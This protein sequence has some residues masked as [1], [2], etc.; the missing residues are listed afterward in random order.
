VTTSVRRGLPVLVLAAAG[1]VFGDIGTSPL[2]SMQMVFASHHGLVDPTRTDVMGVVSTVVWCL[3][4]IVSI[5]Y[6]G[7][8]LRADNEGEGGILSLAALLGRKLGKGSKS[9]AIALVLAMVGAALFYGD[10]LITPAVSVLSAVEG[11]EVAQPD[12]AHWVVPIAVVILAALFG[13]QRWGTA[14][15]GKAFGPIMVVWFVV[16]AALGI[17]PILA[18]PDILLALSPTYALVFIASHP[19]ISFIA[20]GAVVLAVT[21]VEALYADMGH[22]GRRPIMVGWFALVFPALI[23]NYLGQ[24]ANVMAHPGTLSNPFFNLAPGWATIPLVVLA[25]LATVIASQAVISGAFSVSRQATRLSYLPRIRV[26]QTSKDE[27]GQI[28]VPAINAILFVGVLLLVLGFRSSQ[29]LASAYGLAVTATLLLEMSL[30]MLLAYKV[31]GWPLWKLAL[32]AVPVGAVELGLFSAN[33]VKIHA[34]G[35]LP[36]S[37]ALALIIIMS[38]WRRGSRLA[39][40]ARERSEGPVDEFIAGLDP[41]VT[42]VPGVAVYPHGNPST[43]PLA[44]RE[45]L[46]VNGVVHEHVVIVTVKSVGVPHVAWKQRVSVDPLGDTDDGIVHVLYRVGFNDSQNVPVAL[47]MAAKR[48]PNDLDFN[49]REATYM[50]SV[51]RIEPGGSARMPRW[52]KQLFRALEKASANRTRVFHLPQSRT[53]VMGGSIRL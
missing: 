15:I 22:F 49:E 20:G 14:V 31:W 11:V 21:G 53:V 40:G 36:L 46:R 8:I 7:F 52:Q 5:S 6:V 26:V 1:V 28:Y 32:Y 48:Y 39:F 25:T 3:V 17:G 51:F 29:N 10:S 47:K 16:I 33:I 35:W 4:L 30:F 27:G 34:G 2:Y 19:Y 12:L 13:I 37:I 45:N 38:T 9:A 50:L 18:H 42:R 41:A 24:G 43:V 23:I 44:L